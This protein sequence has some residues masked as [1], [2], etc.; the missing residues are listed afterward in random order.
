MYK[1]VGVPRSI[2][3]ATCRRIEAAERLHIAKLPALERLCRA[4]ETVTRRRDIARQSGS[5]DHVYILM[6][7]MA[8]RYIILPTGS[9]RI[10]AIL[11]PGDTVNEIGGRQ[12]VLDH[13]IMAVSDCEVA[14]PTARE[15]EE[16]VATS[17]SLMEALWRSA[18]AHNAIMRQWLA[19]AGRRTAFEMIAHLLCELHVRMSELGMVR[20]DTFSLPL[21]QEEIGD[22]T[23]LTSVHV[24][25]TFKVLK[26]NSL[27]AR[28]GT[29]CRLL[30][31]PRLRSLCGFDPGYLFP[32][33]TQ[34]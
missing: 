8:A 23:G 32:F 5:S 3:D 9:R 29:D 25:R 33:S 7:G 15:F 26:E 14:T 11:L 31:V 16:N 22:A 30:D 2:D 34:R 27:I 13:N 6:G 10:T 21:T 18:M 12:V 1:G 28:S 24:N 20:D 19:S 4:R 17:L